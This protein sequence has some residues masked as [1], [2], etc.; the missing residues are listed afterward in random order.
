MSKYRISVVSFS[1]ASCYSTVLLLDHCPQSTLIDDGT[2]VGGYYDGGSFMDCHSA[3][4][5]IDEAAS[6]TDCI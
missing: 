4:G 5:K 3:F 6:E 2:C 1:F